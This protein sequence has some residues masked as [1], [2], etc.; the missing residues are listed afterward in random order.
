[1]T[2]TEFKIQLIHWTGL[3]SNEFPIHCGWMACDADHGTHWYI[4]T[5]HDWNHRNKFLT[6]NKNLIVLA[7]DIYD[8]NNEPY[9]KWSSLVTLN[10]DGTFIQGTGGDHLGGVIANIH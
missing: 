2:P 8:N 6:M 10:L 5:G 3:S 1:M 9:P 7:Y 4:T